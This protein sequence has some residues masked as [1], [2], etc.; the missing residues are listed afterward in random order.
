MSCNQRFDDYI[1]NIGPDLL[2]CFVFG[3]LAVRVN[4]IENCSETAL[5][6]NIIFIRVLIEYEI[7]TVFI[8]RVVC[9][10]HA[11]VP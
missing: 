2:S 1:L 11:Q 10:M 6:A 5:V 7:L 8:Y 3:P 9:Q 4:V